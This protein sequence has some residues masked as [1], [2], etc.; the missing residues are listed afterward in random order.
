MKQSIEISEISL[1][2][3]Y[4]DISLERKEMLRKKAEEW[5]R[6]VEK[7]NIRINERK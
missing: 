6:L 1:D 3:A 2:Y 4:I 7:Y 5:K